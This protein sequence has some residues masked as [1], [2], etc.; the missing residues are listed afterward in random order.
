MA[1]FLP[2]TRQSKTLR[3]SLSL[4]AHDASITVWL[5]SF[6]TWLDSFTTSVERA[7][8]GSVFYYRWTRS[9]SR[10][11]RVR[12]ASIG[13]PAQPYDSIRSNRS[14]FRLICWAV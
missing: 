1:T 6:T 9:S 7:P 5:D 8:S 14:A 4:S 12:H 11:F 13:R 3:P 2:A 10:F